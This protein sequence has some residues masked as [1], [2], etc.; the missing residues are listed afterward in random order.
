MK[1]FLLAILLAG[2]FLLI[3]QL[4]IVA[5]QTPLP[6]PTTVPNLTEIQKT[7]KELED[8]VAELQGQARTLSSQ[9]AVM[10][11]QIRLTQLRIDKTRKALKSLEEDIKIL[12]G[13]I[14]NLEGDLD[15]LSELLLSRVVATYKASV[16]KPWQF[17]IGS[18]GFSDFLYRMQYLRIAQENDKKLIFAAQATKTNFENQQKILEEKQKEVETLSRQLQNLASQLAQQKKDKELLFEIT[19]NDEHRYQELL[20]KAR[21]EQAAILGIIAGRGTVAEVGPIKTGETISSTIAGP[22][23]CSSGN[24]LHFEVVKDNT[25]Q[26]PAG[27]L[28]NISLDFGRPEDRIEPFTPSGS[29]DWPLDE[30]IRINQEYGMTFY[31]RLGW[32][33]GGPHTGIDMFPKNLPVSNPARAKAVKDGTLFRGSIGCGGG[34]LK[35]ARV[36]HADGIQT[37]Y[38]HIN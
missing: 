32:Y 28:K 35:F 24:H 18:H 10:D 21:A 27:Y 34:T 16:V 36:D 38:L 12:E 6:T 17:F 15:K 20:E 1:K 2:F 30:P 4:A 22:S 14:V 7:I 31:A 26:N 29:W 8:K 25:H 3:G 19:R 33:N 23:A 9:I 37:Y 5:S 11:N 13:K